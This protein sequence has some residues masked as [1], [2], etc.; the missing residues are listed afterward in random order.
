MPKRSITPRRRAGWLLEVDAEAELERVLCQE[1][2]VLQNLLC[3]LGLRVP[4]TPGVVLL[5]LPVH[6][7]AAAAAGRR[8]DH[9]PGLVLLQQHHVTTEPGGP[10]G[11]VRQCLD[12]ELARESD[13]LRRFVPHH[14]GKAWSA[15]EDS[16]FTQFWEK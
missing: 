7:D 11:E 9:S 8:E 14:A 10:P 13:Y 2:A 1:D 4:D 12:D 16:L 5:V 15:T 6:R 3:L